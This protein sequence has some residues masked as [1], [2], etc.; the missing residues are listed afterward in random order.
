M[1]S[2]QKEKIENETRNKTPRLSRI[3]KNKQKQTKSPTTLPVG[4]KPT[5]R[6]SYLCEKYEYIVRF[7][8]NTKCH[9]L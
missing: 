3:E 4:A 2:F 7:D 1:Q 9:R 6:A 8:W 5:Q